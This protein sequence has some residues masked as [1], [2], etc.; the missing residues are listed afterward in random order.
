[1]EFCK[2]LP[3]QQFKKLAVDGELT[4]AMLNYTPRNPGDRLSL[5]EEAL[6]A[7]G[8]LS[9]HQGNSYLAQAGISINPS[10]VRISGTILTPPEMTFR[11]RTDVVCLLKLVKRGLLNGLTRNLKMALGIPSLQNIPLLH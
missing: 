8:V 4:A 11:E 9:Y 1:M 5:I 3:G 7:T 10:P 6:K 2:L